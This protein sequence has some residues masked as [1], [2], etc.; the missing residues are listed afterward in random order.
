MKTKLLLLGI[1]I[2]VLLS[3]DTASADDC[4][5]FNEQKICWD[6]GL[7]TTLSWTYPAT[8]LGAYQIEIRDFN[9]L[10]SFSI[11]VSKNGIV[12]EGL[13]SEGELYLFNFSGN[14]E[15]EGIKV[16]ADKVSNINSFPVNIGTYPSDPQAKISIWLSVKEEKKLPA[17]E[18]SIVSEKETNVDS[19]ITAYIK[20]RNSGD[21]DLLNTKVLIFYDGLDVMNEFDF[22]DGSFNKVTSLGYEIKWENISSYTLTSLNHVIMRDGYSINVLNFSNGSVQI[23]VSHDGSIKSDKLVDGGSTVFDFARENEYLGIKILGINISNAAASLILQFPVKNSLKRIYTIIPAQSDE[24]IKLKF[25][26]PPSSRKTYTISA[27]ASGKDKEGNNYTNSEKNTISFENTFEVGKFAS[28][29]ILNDNLYN[30]SSEIGNIISIKNTTHVTIFV[31]NLKDFPV[32]GVKLTDTILSGFHFKDDANKTS[33]TWIF[34]MKAKE[35]REFKYELI[36]QRQGVYILPQADLAWPEWGDDV[37]LQSNSP[38]TTVSGPYI[39]MERSFNRS[40]IAKGDTLSVTISITNNGDL[41]EYI[42][43]ND[44]VPDNASFISGKLS[45]SGF[46]RPMEN[47]QIGYVI[48]VNGNELDFKPPEM[49]SRNTGYQWYEPLSYKKISGYSPPSI[50]LPSMVTPVETKIYEKQPDKG[51]VQLMNEKF[52]WFEGSVSILSLLAGLFLLIFLNK[53]KYFRSYEK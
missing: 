42:T 1:L 7:E 27:T 6:S 29:S 50:P 9:W 14:S 17:P 35:R 21:F 28:N 32:Y 39:I 40:T 38:K 31:N 25:M 26:M 53:K 51:I 5:N 4:D 44:N 2:S 18:L 23:N 46:L 16:I 19:V 33:I 52:P 45:F 12:K 13:L 34:N 37:H 36:P 22:N 8:S 43:I 49:R 41:P 3:I 30:D 20:T 47:A 15:F 24:I 10:G 11:R 48:S